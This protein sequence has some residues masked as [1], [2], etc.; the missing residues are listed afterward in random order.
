[1]LKCCE[2][3]QEFHPAISQVIIESK[4]PSAFNKKNLFNGAKLFLFTF[5][6]NSLLYIE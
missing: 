2:F 6:N 3:F 1:M 4:F 5:K